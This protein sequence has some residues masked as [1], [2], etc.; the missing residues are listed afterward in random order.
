MI[1]RFLITL[2]ILI[3]FV[4]TV[5][6]VTARDIQ[7]LDPS[8][9]TRTPTP[10]PNQPPPNPTATA[11]NSG[12]PGN[13]PPPE[14]T[15]TTESGSTAPTATVPASGTGVASPTT[16]GIGVSTSTPTPPGLLGGTLQA[17]QAGRGG[18]TDTPYAE[19]IRRTIVYAGPGTTFGPV[20][21]LLTDEMRPIVGRAAYATWWQILLTD[22][23]VGWVA[24]VDVN[25]Y[26]N[27]ALVPIVEPPAIG[28]A[29][30][31]RGT[32][33]NPT[34][35]PLLTCVPTPTPTATPTTSPTAVS[36]Q[37]ESSSPSAGE[38][39]AESASA[40]TGEPAGMVMAE[41]NDTPVPLADSGAPVAEEG[42]AQGAGLSS[43]GTGA[44]RTAS[45]TSATNLI[46][47]LG[48]LALIAGGIILA[49]LSRKRGGETTGE[50]K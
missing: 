5:A 33:W 49:L 42:V 10:D 18:C 17:S 2:G 37:S 26:G 15:S 11:D 22:E 35:L 32:P 4:C 36:A 38:G 50:T 20:A 23:M 1:K 40:P 46:L 3:A 6:V 25:E 24:D 27:T 9:P 12:N 47:P 21:T 30:P 13:P 41:I 7:A 48:G 14:A 19:A 45:P 8:F 44:S 28:G 29:T 31:T 34:P 43:R 16:T 39:A